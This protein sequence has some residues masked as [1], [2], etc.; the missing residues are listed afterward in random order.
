MDTSTFNYL[1]S[2]HFVCQQGQKVSNIIFTRAEEFFVCAQTHGAA[3]TQGTNMF[4]GFL[5]A[6]FHH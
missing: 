5:Y 2:F 6:S 4:I 3:L 1:V